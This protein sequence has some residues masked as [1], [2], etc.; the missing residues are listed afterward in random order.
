MGKHI[1][2]PGKTQLGTAKKYFSEIPTGFLFNAKNKPKIAHI[3]PKLLKL[4]I[5]SKI[6][7]SAV[8]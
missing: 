1:G 3:G 2:R 5:C 4:E 6:P 7:A 8:I